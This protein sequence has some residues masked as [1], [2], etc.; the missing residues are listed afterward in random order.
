M[1]WWAMAV[2]M[3]LAIGLSILPWT[4][5]HVVSPYI[6][7]IHEYGHAV[8]NILTLGRP[9]GIKAH[10]ANGG[11]ETHSMRPRGFLSGIGAIISGLAGYPAPIIMGL[12]LILSVPGGW[13][14]IMNMTA[15]I[16]FTIFILLMRNIAG[17]LLAISTAGYFLLSTMN[18]V[19]GESLALGAGAVLLVG[20]VVDMV[21]LVGYWV[22]GVAGETDLG[23]LQG[24]FLLPKF[25]WLLLMLAGTAAAIL[26]LIAVSFA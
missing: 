5:T 21:V 15:L 24:R 3:L 20:G 23:I 7:V 19:L 13:S 8:A 10:F 11:G 4:R 18:P 25:V 2:P 12:A 17:F 16:L 6:T 14:H 26:G 1:N 22:R 9:S